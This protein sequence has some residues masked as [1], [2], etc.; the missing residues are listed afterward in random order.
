MFRQQVTPKGV[1]YL[2]RAVFYRP[3]IPNGISYEVP[4]TSYDARTRVTT[5]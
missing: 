1:K 3:V 2:G 4:A 5:R